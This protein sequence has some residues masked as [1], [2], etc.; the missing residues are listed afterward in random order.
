[1]AENIATQVAGNVWRVM[2]S[3]GDQVKAGDTLF[4]LELMKT[5]VPHL[6]TS[7]GRVTRV[8]ISEGDD[9]EADQD[10]VILE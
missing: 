8:A 2:V 3:V 10:A 6:A 7:D 4:I 5:E 9:V 1:M